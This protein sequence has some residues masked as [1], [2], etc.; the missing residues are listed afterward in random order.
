MSEQWPRLKRDWVGRRVRARCA[1]RNGLMA[2]PKGAVLT[3]RRGH[4]RYVD[5]STVACE[6]CGVAVYIRRVAVVDVELLPCGT[7]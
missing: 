7:T 4:D 1:L 2:V 6:S 3:V 5:L